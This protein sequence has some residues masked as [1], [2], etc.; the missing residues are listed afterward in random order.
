MSLYQLIYI[1]KA[2]WP[3]DVKV[4]ASIS[5]SSQEY[6]ASVGVTGILLASNTHFFQVLEGRREAV[7]HVYAEV[8][9]DS[10]HKDLI[11]VKYGAVG[12]RMFA[13]WSMKGI[14]LFEIE[15]QLSQSLREVYGDVAGEFPFPVEE[16]AVDIFL[17]HV[18][19]GLA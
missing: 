2:S 9:R 19:K 13:G 10:R 17:D 8:M 3:I 11:L 15:N 6:N 4:I 7:N 1:S 14:G 5:E 18:V 12:D 16:E